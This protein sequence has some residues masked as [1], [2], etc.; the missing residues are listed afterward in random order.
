MFFKFLY[1]KNIKF[2]LLSC[3]FIFFYPALSRCQ[4]I[5]IWDIFP[6]QVV[7]KNFSLDKTMELEIEAAVGIYKSENNLLSNCWI[8]DS[9][10]RNLV[11]KFPKKAAK[12]SRSRRLLNL[13]Q[14]ITLSKG[15]Y[16]VFYVIN[17]DW[18]AD[19]RNI[20][21]MI[22]NNPGSKK[23]Q[24]PAWGITLKPKDK[25]DSGHFV[26]QTA[27]IKDS[28]AMVQITNIYD[29]EYHKKGFTLTAPVEVRIYAI[30]EGSKSGREMYDF[31][32]LTNA[33]TRQRIWEM[34]Y[35]KTEHAGGGI[36]NR[37]FDGTLTL[38]AGDYIVHFVSDDSH[39]NEKWNQ[40]PPHDPAYYGIT[41][42]ALATNFDYTIIKPLDESSHRFPIVELNRIRNNRCENA[43][44]QL[45]KKSKLYIFALGEGIGSENDMADFGW[46]INATTREFVWKMEYQHTDYAGGGQKNRVF[47]GFIILPPGKYIA[48]YRTDD[49]H[50]YN[51][52]NVDKPWTPESWGI[53]I[54][55][56]EENCAEQ[57]KPYQE[58]DD[59]DLLVQ[60]IRIRDDEKVYQ[61][62]QTELPMQIRIY[63][64]GEGRD[65]KMFDYGWIETD[66]GEKI[67]QMKFDKTE[68]AGGG[69]KNRLFNK[70]IK[71]QPGKYFV[72][73]KSDDSHSYEKWNTSPPDDQDHWGITIIKQP[74]R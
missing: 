41:I 61:H 18:S 38:P 29:N 12:K 60:M 68:P 52:W 28:Q 4:A 26:L 59:A 33:K 44:F 3:F 65:D 55:C 30:G 24:S 54:S 21:D 9:E 19:R 62:F 46:I 66:S 74:V 27:D 32:W 25:S 48:Y 57:V 7:S 67:W 63:C 51:S 35:R 49:S 42:W 45:L 71:L 53:S 39:S 69:K 31:A 14:T 47:D 70:T 16:E 58:R 8:L 36:K 6:E 37:K 23:S 10:K 11:W 40:M 1:S 17:P 43:G 22:F 73:Y 56:A 64:I 34:K 72:Y 50:A 2:I 5:E 13:E 15:A 20:F